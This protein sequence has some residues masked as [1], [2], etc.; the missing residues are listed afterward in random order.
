M[1]EEPKK[2]TR[3]LQKR[4]R[5]LIKSPFNLNVP[6]ID[7]FCRLLTEGEGVLGDCSPRT[8]LTPFAWSGRLAGE[9]RRRRRKIVCLSDFHKKLRN[10]LQPAVNGAASTPPGNTPST[11]QHAPHV[12]GRNSSQLTACAAQRPTPAAGQRTLP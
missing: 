3:G 1:G 8:P 6:P 9:R 2:R 5:Q 11:R 7:F 4:M 12:R 10:D